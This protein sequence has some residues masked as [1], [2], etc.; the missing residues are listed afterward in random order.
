MDDGHDVAQHAD[1]VQD[2]ELVVVDERCRYHPKDHQE[3]GR[4]SQ[5]PEDVPGAKV[6]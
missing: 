4:N 5:N 6:R 3:R 1:E 2:L